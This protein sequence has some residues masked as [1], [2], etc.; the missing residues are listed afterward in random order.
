MT[1]EE[2]RR[3]FSEAMVARLAT[4]DRSGRPH[5]VPIVFAVDGDTVV[6]AVDHKPKS[7][8]SLRRLANIAENPTVALLVDEYGEDWDRLWWARAD[9]SA[10]VLAADTVAARQ[11]VDLLVAR[12]PQYQQRRPSGQVLVVD[13]RRWSGWSAS[14]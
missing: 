1:G 8:T 6:S 9:G 11:A 5:L 2:A 12:Y 4:S 3:R 10:R 14:R 13:V 7:T